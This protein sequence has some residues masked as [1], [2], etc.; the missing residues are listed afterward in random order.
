MKS[1]RSS[2]RAQ[3]VPIGGVAIEMLSIIVAVTL[4]FLVTE[5][6][7]DLRNDR[8]AER[9]L[10]SIVGEIRLNQKNLAERIPYYKHINGSLDSLAKLYGAEPLNPG[11]LQGEWKGL[12]PPFLRRASYEAASVTGALSHAELSI[13]NQVAN[14][15]ITQDLVTDTFDW[16]LHGILSGELSSWNDADRVFSMLLEVVGIAARTYESVLE[17]L[18]EHNQPGE[19]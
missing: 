7:E 6:R 12:N 11:L 5:W 14:A 17:G 16:T 8:L 10:N 1:I 2:E 19:E 18:S 13:V 4:G 3:R 9:G 15:Y